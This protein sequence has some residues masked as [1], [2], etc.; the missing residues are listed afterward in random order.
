MVESAQVDEAGRMLAAFEKLGKREEVNARLRAWYDELSAPI[1]AK[2]VPPA[3]PQ[4]NGHTLTMASVRTTTPAPAPVVE[5]QEESKALAIIMCSPGVEFADEDGALYQCEACGFKTQHARG[6]RKHMTQT[7]GKPVVK[8]EPA[9]APAVELRPP[10]RD[11]IVAELIA[12]AKQLKTVDAGAL[13][14]LKV[15]WEQEFGS[16]D[17]DVWTPQQVSSALDQVQDALE[18]ASTAITVEEQGE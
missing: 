13:S 6:M 1:V 11:P 8:A 9:T 2:I 16:R 7:H 18:Y 14:G 10:E 12:K 5:Q 3:Q 15:E 17:P 4:A